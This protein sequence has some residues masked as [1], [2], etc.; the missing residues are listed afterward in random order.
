M[1]PPL[2]TDEFYVLY[3][4]YALYDLYNLYVLYD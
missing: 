4:F 1:S 3:E 2:D